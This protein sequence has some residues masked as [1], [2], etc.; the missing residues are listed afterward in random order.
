MATSAQAAQ[1][2]AGCDCHLLNLMLCCVDVADA[3]TIDAD[4]VRANLQQALYCDPRKSCICA[5]SFLRLNREI[6]LIL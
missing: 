4:G 6:Q 2:A 5:T 3:D 1:G